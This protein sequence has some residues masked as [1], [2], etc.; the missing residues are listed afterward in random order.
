MK[1]TQQ[2]FL[3]GF[4]NRSSTAPRNNNSA[5][6]R[7]SA[8]RQNNNNNNNNNVMINISSEGRTHL[9]NYG[10]ANRFASRNSTT[11]RNSNSVLQ[12]NTALY[13]NNNN[14]NITN[15]NSSS[16][17]VIINVSSEGRAY[18]ADYESTKRFSAANEASAYKTTRNEFLD[19]LAQDENAIR[20]VALSVKE[21][22]DIFEEEMERAWFYHKE[23][24]VYFELKE[25][26]GQ[27]E[28][29]ENFHNP[30]LG[31]IYDEVQTPITEETQA[32]AANEAQASRARRNVVQLPPRPFEIRVL[33]TFE[34]S[35]DY[36]R[37]RFNRVTNLSEE[38][39]RLLD[40]LR[41]NDEELFSGITCPL[42]RADK[43]SNLFWGLF[44]RYI[45]YTMTEEDLEH[46]RKINALI[47]EQF[48]PFSEVMN[49]IRAEIE[50]IIAKFKYSAK[51]QA[52]WDENILRIVSGE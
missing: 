35:F 20:T 22:L 15:T 5:L 10:S 41:N 48:N 46:A 28:N 49:R 34:D 13:Q 12:R 2:P 21:L 26:S 45:D 14:S 51:A 44:N 18:L 19:N 32:R 31:N 24:K 23:N 16:N 33:R 36:L 42:E 4:A 17:D 27:T 50:L 47:N 40:L 43:R 52:Q 7:S 9:A 1:I 6:Q 8:L 11:P 38:S 39:R 3:N 37:P 25:I 30:H 29:I